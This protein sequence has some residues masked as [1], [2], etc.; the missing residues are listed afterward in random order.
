MQ[1]YVQQWKLYAWKT[2]GLAARLDTGAYQWLIC[3]IWAEAVQLAAEEVHQ[4]DWQIDVS[5]GD[6]LS[7][8]APHKGNA[9]VHQPL[10]QC[11]YLQDGAAVEQENKSCLS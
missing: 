8:V 6:N 2:T 11:K 5:C 9:G 3:C 10:K 4:T 7:A 1:A